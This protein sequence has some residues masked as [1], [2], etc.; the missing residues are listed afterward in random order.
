MKALSPAKVKEV[1][2]DED[3]GTAEVD[4]ARLPAVAG[5]RQGGPERPPGRPP[6]RLARRHQ[7]RDAAR[8]GGGLRRARSGPRAS[9]SPTSRARW[10]GSRPRVARRCPPPRPAGARSRRR[11]PPRP[12]KPKPD[13]NVVVDENRPVPRPK[14][15]PTLPG[16]GGRGE[17]GCRRRPRPAEGEVMADVAV[18]PVGRSAP[19][20]AAGARPGRRGLARVA[21]RSDGSLAVGRSSRAG[22]PGCAPGRRACFDAAVRRGR[23]ARALRGEVPGA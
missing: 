7:E 6:H 19:A 22:A 13:E 23:S 20:S 2:I 4:R 1:R 12:T 5:H 16:A 10:C 17:P 8:R 3:T 11:G 9:G 14:P 15:V 21:R 18:R